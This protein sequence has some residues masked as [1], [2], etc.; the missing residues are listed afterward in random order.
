MRDADEVLRAASKNL[1]FAFSQKFVYSKRTRLIF[2]RESESS[3][4]RM[5]SEF[6]AKPFCHDAQ[7]AVVIV[8]GN[9]RRACRLQAAGCWKQTNR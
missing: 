7:M 6:S 4:R 8:A 9:D 3:T 5:S 2:L 1:D